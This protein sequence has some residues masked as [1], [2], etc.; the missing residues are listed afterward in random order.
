MMTTM[1][2]MGGPIA[3]TAIRAGDEEEQPIRYKMEGTIS[4]RLVNDIVQCTM[5]SRIGVNDFFEY[6]MHEGMN[7][8][9]D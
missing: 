3:V 2:E 9:T 1:T 4:Y 8:I 5:L 6:I 7:L